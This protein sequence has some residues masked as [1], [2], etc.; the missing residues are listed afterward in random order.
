MASATSSAPPPFPSGLLLARTRLS[1]QKRR[2]RGAHARL[3]AATPPLRV[4]DVSPVT[5]CLRR[6]R[7]AAQS[8][9]VAGPPHLRAVRTSQ[10]HR[11]PPIRPGSGCRP[12][13][14]LETRAHGLARAP[15]RHMRRQSQR[16]A[17]GSR[18]GCGGVAPRAACAARPCREE[19]IRGDVVH[20]PCGG[21]AERAGAATLTAAPCALRRFPMG[22]EADRAQWGGRPAIHRGL[23]GS[24]CVVTPASLR[25]T[26]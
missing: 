21:G 23:M 10:Q 18:A 25:L 9:A 19:G 16:C 20:W 26:P 17:A 2:T 5:A 11:T 7:G 6:P 12:T 13:A 24:I 14:R 4:P 3:G 1:P 8:S 15:R 22:A